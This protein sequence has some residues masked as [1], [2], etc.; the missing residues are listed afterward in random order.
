MTFFSESDDYRERSLNIQM[1]QVNVDKQYLRIMINKIP[2]K[3]R[4]VF[5]FQKKVTSIKVNSYIC[6]F[7]MYLKCFKCAMKIKICKMYR[8]VVDKLQVQFPASP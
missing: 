4:C 6:K 3:R 7:I 1:S 5:L 8:G 2:A